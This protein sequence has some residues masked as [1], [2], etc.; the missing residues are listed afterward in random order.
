MRDLLDLSRIES[1]KFPLE[2]ARVDLCEQMRRAL[3]SFEGRI[4]QKH[5]EV[6]A[7]L[8]EEPCWVMADAGRIRQVIGNLIDNA[9]KFLPEGGTLGVGVGSAGK[10]VYAYV[11]DNG[12]GISADDLPFIFDRFYKADKA[13]PP[14][15]AR[16]WGYPSSSASSNSTAAISPY[17]PSRAKPYSALNL[18]R[19][20][21]K[22]KRRNSKRSQFVHAMP[23]TVV[24]TGLRPK[25][26][27]GRGK[28]N[29]RGKRSQ[30]VHANSKTML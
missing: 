25:R 16:G 29:P 13:L 17:P 9:L 18:R 20:R 21:K 30:F 6:N 3:L 26:K 11:E 5:V 2:I 15:W 28:T 27:G 4:D 24:Y 8:C 22:K 1:G 19:R 7:Q 14:A 10:R 23:Q 12:P